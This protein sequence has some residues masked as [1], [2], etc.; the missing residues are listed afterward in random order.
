[1]VPVSRHIPTWRCSNSSIIG[2]N[3]AGKTAFFNCVTGFYRHEE[4]EINI[5]AMIGANGAGKSTALNTICGLLRPR[6]GS[7]LL[8]GQEIHTVPAHDIVGR[9]VSQAPE[10]RGA[11]EQNALM[12]LSVANR[13][14]VLETGSVALE[15]AVD[16]LRENPQVKAAYLGR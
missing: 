2:P 5:V 16:E 6:Y 4:G 9:G 15:G 13:G 12:A 14:Y 8:E 11:V 3:G 7:V 1:M 10:G